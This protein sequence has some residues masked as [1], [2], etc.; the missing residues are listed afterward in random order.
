MQFQI[1]SDLHIERCADSEDLP[2]L[3]RLAPN[4]CLLG[5]IGNANSKR[6]ERFILECAARFERVFV[7]AGNH[8][9]YGNSIEFG[10]WKIKHV[11]DKADNVYFLNGSGGRAPQRR[12]GSCSGSV[13]IDNIRVVG[14]TLW[15]HVPP[16][17]FFTVTNY[18]NDYRRIKKFTVSE[19]NRLHN[20]AVEYIASEIQEAKNAGQQIVILTHHAP[21]WASSAPHYVGKP[22]NCA[23]AT[24]LE[25][26]FADQSHVRL[27]GFGHTH[28]CIDTVIGNT[29]VVSNCTG[30]EGENTNRK[31]EYLVATII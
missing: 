9:Y 25:H 4:L 31:R 2:F 11:C 13:V 29:R 10:N 18:I 23:F 3:E 20:T 12:N 26:L 28:W 6:Y 7:V 15:S 19:N 14:T 21:I 1:H 24:R 22:T 5:D 8:E 30:Y 16:E 27:W 17:H